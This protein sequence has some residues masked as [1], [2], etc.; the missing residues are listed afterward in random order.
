MAYAAAPAD[1]ATAES[2]PD[3]S[4]PIGPTT[5]AGLGAPSS[6]QGSVAAEARA[7]ARANRA[8]AWEELFSR[9]AARPV[10]GS[11]VAES[12]LGQLAKGRLKST[13]A[14]H[15]VILSLDEEVFAALGGEA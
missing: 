4:A 6:R 1:E 8:A 15:E 14:S 12:T 11:T 2:A 10:A 3:A 13:E 7:A 9:L 5:L